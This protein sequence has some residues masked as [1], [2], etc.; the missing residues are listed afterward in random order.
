MH[1]QTPPTINCD[2]IIDSWIKALDE[3]SFSQ[4]TAKPSATSWSVGQ[5]YMH[6]IQATNYFI[7]QIHACTTSNDHLD[8]ESYP[9]ARSMFTNNDFPDAL[10]DGPPSNASTPQPAS[11]EQLVAALKN[12]KDEI[13]KAELL[14]AQTAFRGKAK[15]F[16]L[17]YFT[18]GE[19]LQFTEM[20]FRHHLRQKKRLDIFLEQTGV[21]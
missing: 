15:H 7:K 16:G 9:E 3:Y 18:A 19:W 4:L 11:K 14:I 8:G 12:V 10:L 6:L 17:G 1:Q 2:A 13:K 21:Q 5:L 20:H